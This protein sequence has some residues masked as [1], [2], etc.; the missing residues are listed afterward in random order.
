M[1]VEINLIYYYIEDWI[2]KIVSDYYRLMTYADDTLYTEQWIIIINRW[3]NE[4]LN[5]N[6]VVET[7]IVLKAEILAV[8]VNSVVVQNLFA[9]RRNWSLK[10][11]GTFSIGIFI[12]NF[13]L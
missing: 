7:V 5:W 11:S 8:C 4:V 9:E 6:W 13:G 12:C 1:Q 10:E 2:H 3:W